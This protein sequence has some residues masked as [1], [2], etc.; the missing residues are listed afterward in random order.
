MPVASLLRHATK[1][2]GADKLRRRWTQK[3]HGSN[4]GGRSVPAQADPFRDLDR[5]KITHLKFQNWS[6]AHNIIAIKAKFD[7]SSIALQ[8]EAEI[9]HENGSLKAWR[10]WRI[11][12]CNHASTLSDLYHADLVFEHIR[13]YVLRQPCYGGCSPF[14][15]R[16]YCGRPVLFYSLKGIRSVVKENVRYR[17]DIISNQTCSGVLL[18][19]LFRCITFFFRL[20]VCSFIFSIFFAC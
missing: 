7:A 14:F 17:T 3:A 13:K 5:V 9:L 19:S 10:A 16:S 6:S 12:V 8:R 18:R 1:P 4:S 20:V 2:T 11:W 15:S